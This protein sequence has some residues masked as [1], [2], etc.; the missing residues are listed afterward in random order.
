MVQELRLERSSEFL[1]YFR[2]APEKFDALLHLVAPHIRKLDTV[3][4]ESDI[5]GREAS[6][7][8]KVT[9]S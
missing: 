9:L 4:R 3:T 2:M 8:I 1:T 7:H 5:S 6:D